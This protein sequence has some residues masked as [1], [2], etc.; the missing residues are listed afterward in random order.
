MNF[1]EAE[2]KLARIAG[3]NYRSLR[4]EKIVDQFGP[5]KTMCTIYSDDDGYTSAPT[6]DLVFQKYEAKHNPMQ[7]IEEAPEDEAVEVPE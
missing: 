1:K 7:H 6:W 4:Y 5:V 3:K 2:A